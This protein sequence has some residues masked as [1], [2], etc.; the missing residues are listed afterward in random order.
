VGLSHE[1]KIKTG[2][3]EIGLESPWDYKT[4]GNTANKGLGEMRKK[5]NR[6]REM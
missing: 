2:G 6:E 3:L 1:K 4:R 5:K